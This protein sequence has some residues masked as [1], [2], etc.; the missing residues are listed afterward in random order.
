MASSSAVAGN[1]PV[2]VPRLQPDAI[3]AAQDMVI[4][5]ASSAPAATIG[6]VLAGLTA[7]TA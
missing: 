6:L 3:G 4:G 1:V 7:A 2:P 5:M